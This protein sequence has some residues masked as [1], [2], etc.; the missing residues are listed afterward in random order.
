MPNDPRIK[1]KKKV[2]DPSSNLI[3]EERTGGGVE[4]YPLGVLLGYFRG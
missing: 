4:T 1:F 2:Y 3:Y